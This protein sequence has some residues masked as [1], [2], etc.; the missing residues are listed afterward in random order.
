MVING[1]T[2]RGSARRVYL[3]APAGSDCTAVRDALT[4]LGWVVVVPTMTHTG[5]VDGLLADVA[6]D[7][8]ALADSDCVV[9]MPGADDLLEATMAPLIGLPVLSLEAVAQLM[10]A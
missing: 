3:A 9:V 7:L 2:P 10:A 8:R 6:A 1:D 4:A 5:T